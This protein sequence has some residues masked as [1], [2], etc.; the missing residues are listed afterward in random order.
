[1]TKRCWHHR[2]MADESSEYPRP[3]EDELREIRSNIDSHIHN[4]QKRVYLR[5]LG[6]DLRKM[7]GPE[8][9]TI[10]G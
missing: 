1:M 4:S 3:T 6:S 2:A 5:H 9:G 10:Q 7:R 8:S